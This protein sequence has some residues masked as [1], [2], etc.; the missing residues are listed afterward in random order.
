MH[1]SNLAGPPPDT[2]EEP[3]T[4]EMQDSASGKDD[5]DNR[6]DETITLVNK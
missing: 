5:T 3:A 4:L 1:I 2:S 6:P